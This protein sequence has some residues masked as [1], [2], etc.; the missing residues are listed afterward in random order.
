MLK[1]AV[2]ALL[3][4][5]ASPVALAQSPSGRGPNGGTVV[6][7]QGHPIEFVAKGQ[8][9]VF[10]LGD[11]DGSPLST[12]DIQARATVQSGGKTTSIPLAPDAP[13]LLTGRLEEPIGKKVP[14][15]FSAKFKVG[16]HTHTMTARFTT[17]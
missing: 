5:A 16:T 15:A 2:V 11:D 12:K 17:D 8:D 13:N 7:S 9:L 1:A 3:V 4:V 6:V 14:V 10:Y